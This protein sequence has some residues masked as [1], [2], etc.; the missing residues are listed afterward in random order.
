MARW[1]RRRPQSPQASDQTWSEEIASKINAQAEDRRRRLVGQE[2]VVSFI[3]ALLFETDPIGINFEENTDEYRPEAETIALRLS[4][5]ASEGDLRRI[6][7]EEF[8][9]WFDEQL[10]GPEVR[11]Q[12]IAT[13]IWDVHGRRPELNP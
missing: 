10:A 7:H 1:F 5:A 9:R 13:V 3:E 8:V 2:E 11:Y 6:V 4:E 12:R